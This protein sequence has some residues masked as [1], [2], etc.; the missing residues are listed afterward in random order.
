MTASPSALP[1]SEQLVLV[2]GASRGLGA[3][4]ARAFL[5]QG[6]RVVV[7]YLNS[8]EA[9]EALAAEAPERALAVQADVRD[10]EA[11]RAMFAATRVHFGE[12]VTTLI[13]NALP[14]FSFNGDARPGP[15]T[16]TW[17]HLDHQLQ[18]VARGALNTVQAALP[19]MRERGVG[20]IVN[21]GTNLF[22][23]P[24]V[25]YHDYTAA[26][27]ALLSLTRTLAHDLGPDGI[28]VN[29]ISGGLLRTTDASAAT[30]EAVF[31]LIAA[32]TPL[33]RVTTPEEFADAALLFASPWGRAITGQ[34][35]VVDG[36]L[37]KD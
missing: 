34:N 10:P 2:T 24:V 31:E 8:A 12:P 14:D 19:G 29:M 5:A 13:N 7:N 35:L 20:R 33:R 17:E 16:L 37:V 25:P 4:L 36:G 30:P 23:N 9:A 11:V 6:A 26:K 28:T 18:G 22:Q 27:A 21:I 3:C 1:L 32:S 15:D